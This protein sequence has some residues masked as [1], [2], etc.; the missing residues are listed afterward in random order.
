MDENSFKS[1]DYE[2]KQYLEIMRPHLGQLM[3]QHVISVCNAWIQRL[4][5]CKE[6]E[7]VLRNKYLLKLCYQLAKGILDV[8]FLKEPTD[9]ELISISEPNF[10]KLS[11]EC[12]GTESDDIGSTRVIF[13]K[14]M[15]TSDIDT[16]SQDTEEFESRDDKTY[17]ASKMSTRLNAAPYN[18]TFFCYNCP[19]LYQNINKFE[20]LKEGYEYRTNN[21]ITKLREI[22]KQ[23]MLL[24]N[25]LQELRE[26]SGDEDCGRE[27]IITMNNIKNSCDRSKESHSTLNSLK[28][29]LKDAHDV[30]NTLIDKIQNMQETLDNLNDMKSQ[31]IEDLKA[32]HRLEIIN[33]KSSIREEERQSYESILDELKRKKETEIN[34]LKMSNLKTIQELTAAKDDIIAEKDNLIQQQNS[35]K[36]QLLEEIRDSK[37]HLNSILE[38]LKEKSSE[39]NVQS[40]KARNSFLE[41]RLHKLEKSKNKCI[42]AFETKLATFEREKH[43]AECSLHLQLARQR[44]QVVSDVADE[45][46]SEIRRTLDKL[47]AKYKDVVAN[48]QA[49]AIQRRMQDQMAVESI[50]QAACGIQ[51][52]TYLSAAGL[53]GNPMLLKRDKNHSYD[54]EVS[55]LFRGNKV[56]NNLAGGGNKSFGD[57]SGYCV[58][59]E[60]GNASMF[61][62]VYTPQRD[63]GDKLRN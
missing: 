20:H 60:L 6:S 57:G 62:K 4:S 30:R 26:K 54:S 43:L 38:K 34:E 29:K 1:L 3:D 37:Q 59:G 23:N 47:E 14:K 12:E 61:E 58:N 18:Q 51:S 17:T 33:V 63:T 7:K 16:M 55:S 52:E 31:E 2:Y 25:E 46:Q 21:I 49:T 42:R 39:E 40:Y 24:H 28:D 27:S 56:F 53:S 5:A 32:K 10:S 36:A 50:L 41:K 15:S 44:A 13:S 48:V 45:H 22:K 9:K 11:S 35:E 8:P 19:E